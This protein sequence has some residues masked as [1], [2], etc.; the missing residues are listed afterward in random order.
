MKLDGSGGDRGELDIPIAKTK[1]ERGAN[2]FMMVDGVDFD[3][4]EVGMLTD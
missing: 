2:T 4:C 1:I 3:L